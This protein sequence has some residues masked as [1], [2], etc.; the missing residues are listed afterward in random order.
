MNAFLW[1]VT[2]CSVLCHLSIPTRFMGLP[3]MHLF[4]WRSPPSSGWA[5][6]PIRSQTSLRVISVNIIPLG[7]T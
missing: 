5:N 7:G 4:A 6:L 2:F 3:F 1:N